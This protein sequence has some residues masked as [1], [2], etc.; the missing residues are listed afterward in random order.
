MVLHSL[1]TLEYKNVTCS[2]TTK[3]GVLHS[4]KTLE[5][6]NNL[7]KAFNNR[8]VLHSLKTLEYK[9]LKSRFLAS[10]SKVYQ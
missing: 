6:K 3:L 9:N 7:Y 8:K 2:R 10:T 5:Y 4:L 1:K